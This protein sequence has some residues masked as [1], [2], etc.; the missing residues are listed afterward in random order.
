M[1]EVKVPKWVEE[2]LLDGERVVSK[3]HSDMVDFYAT[4]KRL[5]RCI[6]KSNP[7]TNIIN[8][9]LSKFI[10]ESTPYRAFG[11]P[12]FDSLEYDKI[13][14]TLKR[15]IGSFVVLVLMSI[16]LFWIGSLIP[17]LM[18]PWFL[19]DVVIFWIAGFLVILFG[20]FTLESRLHFISL[21]SNRFK[22]MKWCILE[23]R[24]KEQK[25]LSFAKTVDEKSGVPIKIKK[26][27]KWVKALS[28]IL[29][30]IYLY[31]IISITGLV[32]GFF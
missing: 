16:F 14:I 21:D 7:F 20:I 27:R 24:R 12:E 22:L 31:F 1:S 28:V 15:R 2:K 18:N 5:L 19:R 4:D 26:M 10:R 3:Y 23:S 30:I 32:Y 25:L 8:T 13:S 11:D 17:F 9:K 29:I 6:N